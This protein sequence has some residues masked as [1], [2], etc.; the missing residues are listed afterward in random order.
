MGGEPWRPAL[1]PTTPAGITGRQ[2]F[3]GQSPRSGWKSAATDGVRR[4]FG[5]PWRQEPDGERCCHADPRSGNEAEPRTE[6]RTGSEIAKISSHSVSSRQNRRAAMRRRT[7]GGSESRL[8][9][10]LHAMRA[11]NRKKE[12]SRGRHARNERGGRTTP[13][14]EGTFIAAIGEPAAAE[15]LAQ[16]SWSGAVRHGIRSLR[17]R[18]TR[19][20]E[21]EP[22]QG[23]QGGFGNCWPCAG[24][25]VRWIEPLSWRN[26]NWG[27]SPRLR[28]RRAMIW[29]L[30][31]GA[32]ANFVKTRA[33]SGFLS[34]YSGTNMTDSGT[35]SGYSGTDSGYSGTNM[36]D[37]GTDSGYSGTDSGYSGFRV[38]LFRFS[39]GSGCS[40]F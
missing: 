17:R 10:L 4:E 9:R 11:V 34:G 35:D 26:G 23:E 18:R 5:D 21:G 40:H 12:R 19:R 7:S 2:R 30:E 38:S 36:T 32:G 22:E 14:P 31:S 13:R 16:R 24:G 1:P 20:A 3:T 15:A 39:R 25:E 29:D 27:F 33:D 6:R 37:S 8:C 28:W